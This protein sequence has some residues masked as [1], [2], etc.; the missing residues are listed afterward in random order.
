MRS[1][2]AG[3]ILVLLVLSIFLLPGGPFT[4]MLVQKT[5]V[6]DLDMPLFTFE[7]DAFNDSSTSKVYDY[8]SSGDVTYWVDVPKNSN[9]T[10]FTVNLTG[11]IIYIYSENINTGGLQGISVGDVMGDGAN[12]IVTG[13][14]GTDGVFRVIYAFN[15]SEAWSHTA[16]SGYYIH[17]TA[18]GDLTSD[19]GNEI[20]IGTSNNMVR[21]FDVSDSGASEN[22][23]YHTSGGEVKAV[24]IGDV[25]ADSGNETAAGAG[26]YV[27][28]LNSTG[29]EVWNYSIGNVIYS[30]FI[31][32][33][34]SDQGDEVIVGADKLYVLNASGNLTWSKDLGSTVYSVHAGNVSVYPGNDIVAGCGNNNVYLLNTTDTAGEVVWQYATSNRVNSV[35]IGD[36]TIDAG[37]EVV[38]G[39][40]DGN[41]YNLNG[42]GYLIW[43][44]ST[45]KAVRS[46]GVANV[47]ADTG[48]EVIAG[49]V[50]TGAGSG[51][52]YSFNFDYFP[53]NMTVAVGSQ[54]WNS[55]YEKLR[56]SETATGSPLPEGFNE[57]LQ[58]CTPVS[59]RCDIPVTFHSDHPGRLTIHDMNFTYDYN[60]SGLLTYQVVDAWS[61]VSGIKVNESIG[62]QSKNITFSNPD[63]TISITHVNISQSAGACDFNLSRGSVTTSGADTVCDV[64]DFSVPSSGS[65]PDPVLL[66]DDT[67]DSGVP[68]TMNESQPY[69]TKQVGSY[70]MKKNITIWNSVGQTFYSIEANTSLNYSQVQGSTYLKVYWGG[71]WC[72]ITPSSEDSGCDGGSPSYSPTACGSDTFYSCKR[73]T[74][75]NGVPDFFRW[76]Q[77]YASSGAE[78]E[79]GGVTN[80]QAN[81]SLNNV[82][83]EQ[84]IWGSTF[85]Y[86]I[87]VSD[88][89]GDNVSVTLWVYE[90]QTG[91]WLQNDTV[92][93][94]GNGTVS[95]NVTSGINWTGTG[96]YLFEYFDYNLSDSSQQFH[97]A[98]NTSAF[99]GPSVLGRNSSSFHAAGNNSQ[100]NRTETVLLS[101]RINDTIS[102][103]W[104]GAGVSCAVWVTTGSVA[105][106]PPLANYT[107]SSG[108]CNYYFSPDSSYSV[109]NQ[110]WRGGAYQDTYYEDSNSSDQNVFI[111]GK[112][113]I[114]FTSPYS[115][116][117]V[118]RNESLT[119]QARMFDEF[120]KAINESTI[121]TSAY[122]CS[123]YLG[124]AFA[125][126]GTFDSPGYC[127]VSYRPNCSWSL[128]PEDFNVTLIDGTSENYTIVSYMDQS[129]V[130]MFDNL[131]V[132]VSSPVPGTVYHR[133][134][135]VELNSSTNDTCKACLPGDH[136]TAWSIIL[137][138]RLGVNVTDLS[139]LVNM[140]NEPVVM[141]GSE[142]QA[143]G[144]NISEW[145]VNHTRVL[146]GGQEVPSEVY[147]WA[148][149]SKSSVD[150]SKAFLD[151]YSDLMFLAN[152]TA[153]ETGNFTVYYG[154]ENPLDHNITY[155]RNSGF[156]S[157]NESPW[158]CTVS[159]CTVSDCTC[160]VTDEGSEPSGNYSAFIEGQYSGTT[161][162]NR[163]WVHLDFDTPLT[164]PYLT[165]MYKAWGE[166]DTG[167]YLRVEAG[168]GTCDL[169][170]SSDVAE[171]SAAWANQTC[172]DTGFLNARSANISVHD[173]GDGG[174]GIDASHAY[175]DYICP[176]DSSG[177][178][179][180]FSSGATLSRSFE[181]TSHVA[182]TGNHTWQ[183]PV[184]EELGPRTLVAN[185]TGTYYVPDDDNTTITVF[186]WSNVS[187][188]NI[189]SSDCMYD[190][191]FQCRINATIVLFCDV[192]DANTS[193]GI[194]GYNVSFY[195][196][197]AYL[198]SNLTNSS[199]TSVYYW[200]NSTDTGDLHNIS[201]NISD[202][203]GLYYNITVNNSALVPFNITT[204]STTGK[205][206]LAPLYEYADNITKAAS[207]VYS[208]NT[209]LLNTGFFPMYSPYV[210]LSVP[211]GVFTG[212][213]SC[214]V[215]ASGSNCSGQIQVTDS[216][217]TAVGNG[218]VE[219]NGSWYNADATLGY[220]T[221]Q[222]ILETASN[223]VLNISETEVNGSIPKGSSRTVA[224]FTV[225][226]FGNTALSN[227]IFTETGQNASYISS[228]VTYTPSSG[229]SV[230][231]AGTQVV[232]V[233]LTVP[234]TAEEGLYTATIYAN[235]TG[236]SCS[237][238]AECW[239][240]LVLSVNVTKFDWEI[241]PTSLYKKLGTGSGNN[242]IGTITLQDNENA[243]QSVYVYVTGNGT[244]YITA[245]ASEVNITNRSTNTLTVFHNDTSAS[246]YE[247]TW[248]VNV[249]LVNSD[250]SSSLPVYNV[251]VTVDI[252]NFTVN[253]TSPLSTSPASSVNVSHVLNITAN[254]TLNGSELASGLSWEAEVGGVDCPI[255]SSSYSAG[256]G[257]WHLNCTLPEIPGNPVNNTLYV[258]A[259][260]TS[261]DVVVKD[262]EEDSVRYA[263]YTPPVIGEPAGDSVNESD[264][265]A[266]IYIKAN[267]TDNTEVDDVW[268]VVTTPSGANSTL[269]SY[270][271][272]GDEYTFSYSNPNTV[273]DYEFTVYSNDSY[274]L[275]VG[276]SGWFE[277][278]EPVVMTQNT[279]TPGNVNLG[280][281]YKFYRPGTIDVVHTYT[282]PASSGSH[283]W[284]IHK[285]TYDLLA[286][287]EGQGTQ[288]VLFSGVDANLSSVDNPL[289][290]D[291][292]PNQTS[293][294][295]TRI[296]LPGTA[297]NI[298][299]GLVIEPNITFSSATIE[300]NYSGALYSGVEEGDIRAFYCANWDYDN[301]QC[302]D[303]EFS[304]FD[305]T[306]TANQ[307]RRTLSITTTPSSAYALAEW[308]GGN[309]CGAS[310]PAP[311]IP[312][313]GGGSTGGGGGRVEI[314]TYTCGNGICESGENIYNC[315]EDCGEVFPFS[316]KTGLTDIV[317]NPG[318]D[319][320]YTFAI[321]NEV[322]RPI[323]AAITVT[324]E[325]SDYVSFTRNSLTLD[326]NRTDSQNVTVIAPPGME[327]GTYTGVV[328]VTSE[329]KTQNIPITMK[330]TLSGLADLSLIVDL[331][332]KS[333]SPGG[334]LSYAIKLRNLGL[335]PTLN[336]TMVYQV[337]D[338]ETGSIYKETNET[339]ML[340]KSLT[341]NKA[342]SLAG[343]DTPLGNYYLD[344][345]AF[346][347]GKSV[348]DIDTFDVVLPFFA[349]TIGQLI[350]AAGIV[351]GVIIAGYFG[352]RRYLKWKLSKA[353]YVFPVDDKKLPQ[354]TDKTFWIGRI[355][356]TNK[357][358][359]YDPNDLTTHMITAGATGSGKSVSA[360]V[361]VEEALAQSIPVIVFDP[362]AQWSGFVKPCR[363]ENLL[364]FFPQFNMDRRAIHSYKGMIYE[365]KDPNLKINFKKY[366]V[367]G[368][369]TV[370][371]LNKLKPGEYD[372]AVANIID[373]MF[374]VGWEESTELRMIVVF[375]EVHRLLEKYGG[376]GGYVWLEKAAREFRKWGIGLV[377]SSQ[378]LADFK[379]AIAGNVLTEI[380]L[381]TKSITDIKKVEE[382]YGASYS[383][384]IS[385][386]AVGVGMIQNPKYNDGKPYFVQF[387]PTWHNPHKITFDE[388]EIYKGFASRLKA[389]EEKIGAMKKSGKD[390]FDVEL[391]LKLASDKLKLGKFRM[392]EIYISS[393]EKH[394]NIKFVPPKPAAKPAEGKESEEKEAPKEGEKK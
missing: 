234:D 383:Q 40:N 357:L 365:V 346:F 347:D 218:T 90:N 252:I 307:S 15:G 95:F 337:K 120:G 374:K 311:E 348:E 83:P 147:A 119:L 128:G 325:V 340:Q 61:R 130:L 236:S 8:P 251:T 55:S 345:W 131:T 31:K 196:D 270:S 187:R 331:I 391:E 242:T 246:Y 273:G 98:Q 304:H 241:S 334:T 329:G 231:K 73:D 312:S 226:A 159:S 208:L 292:F 149:G 175:I 233:N 36:A 135:P 109:G 72:D 142:L 366:M 23:N 16:E 41:I 344:V 133:G 355:A 121:N 229:M 161:Q 321:T 24:S 219:V 77:P 255:N 188:A 97:Y 19:S 376:K 349:T 96:A 209:T 47:T 101:V 28:L 288:G 364:R 117:R 222:S 215:I 358:A 295:I 294:D 65:V 167:A 78:Y 264:S 113:T 200:H 29:E 306:I 352:R 122:N 199:G 272:S 228:W 257:L 380:Q 372:I 301:R 384:K 227:V 177:S 82:T 386:Q 324:G 333:V 250:T 310:E 185:A 136:S 313:P 224:N 178:C 336:I 316:V 210:S 183:M 26:S 168:G 88:S 202:E 328:S 201:C 266:T 286:E 320:S 309:I 64:T 89:D 323:S 274:G 262:R 318:E 44:F 271:L 212:T 75:G 269:T 30:V 390:T 283:Q 370:F 279:T 143:L 338:A 9:M 205:I 253:I 206:L 186:G 115:G 343:T 162:A 59:G 56:N 174:T 80:L 240:S 134:D 158:S 66:W 285:R 298:I 50:P 5:T 281:T 104:V 195:G 332:T 300:L 387:R 34:T 42:T 3:G 68:V 148:D 155:M 192:S 38:A 156:E 150:T 267:V 182:G 297:E 74:G 263:D 60:A 238:P 360:S 76:L 216:Y 166:F 32:N 145:K 356:E 18:I 268:V 43:S 197:G 259:N 153:G 139:S 287:I 308:C 275:S 249:S 37:N 111:R 330:V 176:S 52:L 277:V 118:Y 248:A 327:P 7:E 6:Y 276:N 106:G 2:L 282:A 22:W 10:G 361:I 367:P 393:L 388:M 21:V 377:M 51:T 254:A 39:S 354:K 140:T 293:D 132:N 204:G 25:A 245:S 278:F 191:T 157:G 58:S 100:V 126:N 67:M 79:G 171:G 125:G 214:G 289:L 244:S 299:M 198:G 381:N 99:A 207:Y 57:A 290:W 363:D 17:S 151:Q 154:Q 45:G 184:T 280:I 71:G 87:N 235:A 112:L 373:S 173:V 261:Q 203:P 14:A 81:L 46:V 164:T 94:T 379:E 339:V 63:N 284:T 165:V 243:N 232:L 291:Y 213:M 138:Y 49:D 92:N 160:N 4:G 247:G 353:R 33:V 129:P 256:D 317:I 260:L 189:S 359:Y 107:N 315:P 62:N 375:D 322:E 103:N 389:I 371:T 223:T 181:Y 265:V 326:A 116:Q 127:S 141:N 91:R 394:L 362:T 84:A 124:E 319:K 137:K 11:S 369:V 163:V 123:F 220:A 305:D 146:V 382:K 144:V 170:V 102:D 368:E 13:T 152:L 86:T 93:V 172:Y 190:G 221:N 1:T 385:R 314:P 48:N 302:D 230:S 179:L 194:S 303:G 217:L 351:T 237:P 169:S 335:T 53:T 193:S 54:Q 105:Y 342:M 341:L 35:V 378:V 211:A 225:D 70:V 20:A 180:S 108:F 27:Y 296:D 239:D 12:E 85:N 69:M 114:N 258:W 350:M 110:T 392:A